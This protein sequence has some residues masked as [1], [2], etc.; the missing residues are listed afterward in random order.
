MDSKV[1]VS[2][3]LA[4]ALA[5][6]V[7]ACGSLPSTTGDE[8]AAEASVV[9]T[10]ESEDTTEDSTPS[11]SAADDT[12]ETT[13]ET[14]TG[15]DDA[16]AKPPATPVAVAKVVATS[17]VLAESFASTGDFTVGLIPTDAGGAVVSDGLEISGEVTQ[18]S[19]HAVTTVAVVTHEALADSTSSPTAQDA[20]IVAVD[21]DNSN[22][23]WVTD[24]NDD[25]ISATKQFVAALLTSDPNS[26][27]GIFDFG[28]KAKDVGLG[29]Q[30]DAS[31]V[32]PLPSFTYSRLLWPWSADSA[33]LQT[34]ADQLKRPSYSDYGSMFQT[35]DSLIEVIHYLD[36]SSSGQKHRAVVL[37]G[38]G[39]PTPWENT[40]KTRAEAI[41][42]ANSHSIPV[43]TVGI[44][45]SSE[46]S[47]YP[48]AQ[49]VKNLKTI[50][51]ETGCV[52]V[53]VTAPNSL[54]TVL[55]SMGAAIVNGH[56]VASFRISPVPP[57][58]TTVYGRAI[59]HDAMHNEHTAD[60]SFVAP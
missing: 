41:A 34:A 4:L 25:R 59:V 12:A 43:C 29:P 10:T 27:V 2:A 60:F 52:Y 54:S 19:G 50:A 30:V 31:T 47:T 3:V 18:P 38:D 32:S 28:N 55:K 39:Q 36:M 13:A 15:A 11:E 21:V 33:A 45:P 44:G 20:R 24:P 23:M 40:Y 17:A 57:N 56:V 8:P 22:C 5:C 26:T 42:V 16:A 46:L 58:G 35:Y 7:T 9:A 49:Y 53:A 1:T 48:N 6:F 14:T 51:K 37:I